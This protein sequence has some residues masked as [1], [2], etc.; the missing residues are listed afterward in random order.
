MEK[1]SEDNPIF[2]I[3]F[4]PERE[5]VLKE[6]LQCAIELVR[7]RYKIDSRIF[8]LLLQIDDDETVRKFAVIFIIV[9]EAQLANGIAE[10]YQDQNRFKGFTSKMLQWVDHFC[11]RNYSDVNIIETIEEFVR[12]AKLEWAMGPL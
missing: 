1:K 10:C 9:W 2:N 12:L 5:D 11:F 7:K 4:Y 3:L 8:E 6:T